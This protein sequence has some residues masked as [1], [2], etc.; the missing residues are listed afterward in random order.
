MRRAR[1]I[2][3]I[4][5]GAT[6]AQS[7]GGG[8]T[9]TSAEQ[10]IDARHRQCERLETATSIRRT[11][12]HDACG[13][14][15]VAAIDGKPRREVVTRAID[16]LKAVWHR[17]AVDADGKTGDGAG[18]HI[19]VPQD[20]FR[21]AGRSAPATRCAPAASASADLP[22]A[23]RLCGAGSLPHHRRI[24]NPAL[25]LLHLRLA[26][27]AGRHLRDRRKGQR[28]APRD[29]ADHV[30]RRRRLDIEELERELYLCRRRIEKRVREAAIAGFL[31]LLA[32]VALADLQG[33]VPGRAAFELLSRPE[34]RA[35]RLGLRDLPSALFDQ[36]LPD[37]AAGPAVPH[38]R[39]QR[40]DQ[41]AEGQRQL[42]EEPR[43]QDGVDA[44]RRAWRRHQ[45]DHPAGQ[46]GFRRARRR[47][48]GAG[49]RR[50]APRRWPR[51]C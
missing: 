3:Y 40:R 49:A 16:A 13:V 10:D 2:S 38:A 26:P 19:Q 36:H 39:P 27:G 11:D 44:V 21:D 1:S 37:L 51:R 30:R 18:I 24:R 33:H 45:A 12:E 46:L 15:L 32:V 17:G 4:Q 6:E 29:R 22:A 34:R 23:H 50:A 8:M 35:L 20:F 48:R 14:G 41:Y 9:R 43:V 31:H 5:A 28:H 42:D 25:R 7:R 47:V